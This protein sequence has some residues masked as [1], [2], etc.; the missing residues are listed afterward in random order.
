MLPESKSMK[1]E[2]S[3]GDYLTEGKLVPG[4]F[5]IRYLIRFELNTYP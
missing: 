1:A 4:G 5:Q 3:L 2:D